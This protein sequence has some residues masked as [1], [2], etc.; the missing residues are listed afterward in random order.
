MNKTPKTRKSLSYQEKRKILKEV[1]E[2]K[3]LSKQEIVKKYKIPASTLSTIM[4]GR[5]K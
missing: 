4:Q 1:D 3:T 5:A 2:N